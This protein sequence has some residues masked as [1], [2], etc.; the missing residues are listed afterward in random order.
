MSDA[1]GRREP[2]GGRREFPLEDVMRE[3][4]GDVR[5]ETL[6]GLFVGVG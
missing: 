3:V 4:L 1:V 5:L 2:S 6:V